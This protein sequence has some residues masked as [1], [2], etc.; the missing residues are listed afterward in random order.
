[1]ESS[2]N[3]HLKNI[4]YA[5]GLKTNLVSISCLEDKGDRVTFVDGKFLVWLKGSNIVYAR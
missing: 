1:M 5:P 2:E 4:L 3:I